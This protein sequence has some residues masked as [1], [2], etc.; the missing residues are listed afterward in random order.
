MQTVIFLTGIV[1]RD[2]TTLKYACA[3]GPRFL[4]GIIPPIIKRP[5]PSTN[6]CSTT[7]FY[8]AQAGQSR[9]PFFGMS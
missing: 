5:R 3:H 8:R 4:R 1:F 9:G 7:R 2:V 6:P